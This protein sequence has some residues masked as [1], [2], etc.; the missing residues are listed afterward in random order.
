VHHLVLDAVEPEALPDVRQGDVT[1][2][3]LDLE[4]SEQPLWVIDPA[5]NAGLRLVITSS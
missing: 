3:G 5:S 2:I 1:S 4:P